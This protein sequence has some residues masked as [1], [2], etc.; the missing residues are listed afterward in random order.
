MFDGGFLEGEI[1]GL[2]SFF[3]GAEPLE[4]F[5]VGSFEGDF[6]VDVEFSGE[7][8]DDEEKVANFVLEFGRGWLIWGVFIEFFSDFGEFFINFF[9]NPGG[10][11]PVESDFGGFFL[12]FG[13]S[14][15]GWESFADIMEVGL[16]LVSLFGAFDVIPLSEDGVSFG[17][18]GLAID[19]GV[20]S[21]EFVGDAAGDFVEVEAVVFGGEFGVE[22][23]LE[24]EV[25]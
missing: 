17:H 15:E 21:D 13:R 8:S 3:N 9:E 18:V 1:L 7:V 23:D 4:E 5:L 6:G 12:E 25:S 14:E 19:M 16:F 10:V 22:D 24:K 2:K 11:G 20:A